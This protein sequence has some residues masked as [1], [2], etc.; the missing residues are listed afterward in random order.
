MSEEQTE[1]EWK[2]ELKRISDEVK[3]DIKAGR[4][5]GGQVHPHVHARKG[6]ETGRLAETRHTKCDLSAYERYSS[7]YPDIETLT[8]SLYYRYF[9][10]SAQ[11]LYMDESHYVDPKTYW[12]KQSETKPKEKDWKRKTFKSEGPTTPSEA[13]RLKRRA[14]RK[15]KKK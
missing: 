8:K 1:E 2:A 11:L 13:V 7:M 10:S 14:E 3:A 9:G 4:Y 12:T 6:T 15:A 5:K